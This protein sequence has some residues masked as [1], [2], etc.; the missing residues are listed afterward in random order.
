MNKANLKWLLLVLMLVQIQPTMAVVA[1]AVIVENNNDDDDGNGSNSNNSATITIPNDRSAT[2]TVSGIGK[3]VGGNF[4]PKNVRVTLD[5]GK[6]WVVP[7]SV[8][9]RADGTFSWAKATNAA[10]GK[11]TVDTAIL[12]PVTNVMVKTVQTA[13]LQVSQKPPEVAA[14]ARAV[15]TVKEVKEVKTVAIQKAGSEKEKNTPAPKG[16][17]SQKNIV[18]LT[19]Q[20]KTAAS[21]N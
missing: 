13:A 17:E 6:T 8:V 15:E 19:K 7:D 21:P 12:N 2:H 20:V 4:D 1:G 10:P 3:I 14:A 11:I 16:S 18:T 9:V 5:G